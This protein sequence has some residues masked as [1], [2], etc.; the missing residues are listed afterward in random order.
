[1]TLKKNLLK[2]RNYEIVLISE[3][4]NHTYKKTILIPENL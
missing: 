3:N 1:M 2:G 4:N